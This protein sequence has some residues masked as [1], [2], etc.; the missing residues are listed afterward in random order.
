[1]K[2]RM[3]PSGSAHHLM[4][5]L[6]VHLHA[7]RMTLKDLTDASGVSYPSVW[8]AMKGRSNIGILTLEA[9][10]NTIGYTLKPTPLPPKKAR[11]AA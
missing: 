1:M 10:F 4:K 8:K 11:V 9:L 3:K 2:R 5:A 6:D 7:E